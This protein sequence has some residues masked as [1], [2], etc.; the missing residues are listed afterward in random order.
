MIDTANS[1]KIGTFCTILNKILDFMVRAK[2]VFVLDIKT[3][4]V[5]VTLIPWS[6]SIRGRAYMGKG[7]RIMRGVTI[8]ARGSAVYLGDQ[9]NICR[10]AVLECA[11]GPIR[12]GARSAVGDFSNVYGQGGASIGEDV[13]M[14]SGVRI[15]PSSHIYTDRHT[16]INSQG[17]EYKGIK[18]SDGVWLGT[19]VVIL[20]GVHVGHSAIVG[21]GAVVTKSI[22]A[23]AVAAGVPAKVLRSRD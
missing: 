7:V 18:I 17:M 2:P 1:P 14:A 15:V 3:E 6:A 23:L 21:A 16:P 12:I 4:K 8:D 19:N 11:G 5:K 20:D 22:P 10:F 13:L 9:A